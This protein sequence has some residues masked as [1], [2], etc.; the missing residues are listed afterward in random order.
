MTWLRG[1]ISLVAAW[2]MGVSAAALTIN[3]S[4]T[5][6]D[7]SPTATVADDQGRALLTRR[8]HADG[9]TRVEL[10]LPGGELTGRVVAAGARRTGQ[11]AVLADGTV[12]AEP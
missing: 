8:L 9:D 5:T 1:G 11:V 6:G 4:V 10:E 3:G 2:S 12:T 7:P